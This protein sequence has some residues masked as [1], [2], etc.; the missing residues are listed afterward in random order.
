MRRLLWIVAILAVLVAVFAGSTWWASK[1]V[2]DFYAQALAGE[3]Q[4]EERKAAAKQ[5]VRQ[6]LRIVEDV[7]F[8][9]RWSEEFR[10]DQINSWLAEELHQK[11]PELVPDG[12]RDPRVGLHDE[13]ISLGFQ[14]ESESWE[15]VVSIR[16]RPWITEPNEMAIEILSIRAGL[17]PI[18]LDE[19]LREVASEIETE[20]FPIRW[21][22]R[23]GNDVAIVTIESGPDGPRLERL[24]VVDGLVRASGKGGQVSDEVRDALQPSDAADR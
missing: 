23:N 6:T 20:G 19:L 8:S 22:Q 3:L 11:Y 12:V 2:P 21:I 10:Q 9:D 24:S 5:F 14:F 4:R 7:E 18:P 15:G 1:Q 17:V 16:V 13:T